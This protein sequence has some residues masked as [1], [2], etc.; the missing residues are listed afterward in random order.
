MKL[1]KKCTYHA[2]AVVEG[3]EESADDALWHGVH[4][5]GG[6]LEEDGAGRVGQAARAYRR[7]EQ[8]G[9]NKNIILI[10]LSITESPKLDIAKIWR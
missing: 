1:K 3:G 4:E 8:L 9:C 7:R 5:L 2:D 10:H 6:E